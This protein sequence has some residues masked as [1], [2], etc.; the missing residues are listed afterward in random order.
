M[1]GRCPM[2]GQNGVD[3]TE[4]HVKE[5]GRDENGHIPTIGLCNECHELH[6]KYVNAL[7]THGYDIDKTK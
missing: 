7:K 1:K 3:L 4:H 6:N 5:L 2:C